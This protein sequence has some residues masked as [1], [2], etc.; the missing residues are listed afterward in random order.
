MWAILFRLLKFGYTWMLH[1]QDGDA[2]QTWSFGGLAVFV[3]YLEHHLGE[4]GVCGDN[5]RWTCFASSNN[6]KCWTGTFQNGGALRGVVVWE[7]SR[8]FVSLLLITAILK[9]LGVSIVVFSSPHCS[10]CFAGAAKSKMAAPDKG[11]GYLGILL[12]PYQIIMV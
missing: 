7:F 2:L 11:C 12:L 3:L 6:V 9:C 10:L 1:F 4:Y 5:C 8:V